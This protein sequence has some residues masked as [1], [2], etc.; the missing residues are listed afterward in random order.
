MKVQ[1][2]MVREVVTVAPETSL[3]DVA[4][5]LSERG[6]SGLPVVDST[7]AVVGV[8]SEADILMKEQTPP[9]KR[10]LLG[11]L[12]HPEDSEVAGKLEARTAGEAMSSPAVTVSAGA[13]VAEAATLMMANDVN[14]LPVVEDGRLAGIVTRHDLVRAFTRDDAEIARE[15]REDVILR[16][17][18][19][20]PET[21]AVQV[22]R[23]VV[24]LSGEVEKQSVAEL[25]ASYVEHLPGV[26]SVESSLSWREADRP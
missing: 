26:V 6:I 2:L 9:E 17:F 10:G 14:R 4:T 13:S 16:R 11:R 24:K 25:L 23:G 20:A 21:V 22:D 1:D 18:W 7:G 5:I 15:I 3:K 12:L 8:V 19:I